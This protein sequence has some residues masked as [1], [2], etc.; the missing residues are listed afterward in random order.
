MIQRLP[1]S[2]RCSSVL[3][4]IKISLII[5]PRKS[6]PF[7]Y[8][9]LSKYT[10]AEDDVQRPIK[11]SKMEHRSSP[12]ATTDHDV[13]RND[14]TA[15]AKEPEASSLSAVAVG[16]APTGKPE[17]GK[18]R[19]A[20]GWAKSRRGKESE[21]KNVG[22]K[23]R[24]TRND[25]ASAEGQGSASAPKGPRYPKR[26]CALLLSFCGTG[27]SGMQ[28]CDHFVCCLEYN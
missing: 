7:S 19:D 15:M 23:R 3:S 2:N 28:M 12:T 20:S 9:V 18:R 5:S 25:E 13:M 22:R 1:L 14:D 6:R 26:Q 8:P 27:C 21:K 16:N 24:G 4:R 17:K 11:R 10:M